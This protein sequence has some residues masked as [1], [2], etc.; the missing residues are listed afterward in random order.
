MCT[1]NTAILWCLTAYQSHYNFR[2]GTVP[3]NRT[4]WVILCGFRDF[5]FRIASFLC[6]K[7]DCSLVFQPWASECVLCR[8]CYGIRLTSMSSQLWKSYVA[9]CPQTMEED[10]IMHLHLQMQTIVWKGLIRWL[11]H[12]GMHRTRTKT[13]ALTV[14]LLIGNVWWCSRV[15]EW[16]LLLWWTCSWLSCHHLCFIKLP[17]NLHIVIVWLPSSPTIWVPSFGSCSRSH[18][19]LSRRTNNWARECCV[20]GTGWTH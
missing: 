11:P 20:S 1:A 19:Q 2:R 6:N 14:S 13:E 8:C 7:G 15:Q 12:R 10:I 3:L 9:G 17:W 18:L 5:L 16:G 4:H